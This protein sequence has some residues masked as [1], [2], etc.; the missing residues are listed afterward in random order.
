MDK[1]ILVPPDLPPLFHVH[2][3][4]VRLRIKVVY[5]LRNVRVTVDMGQR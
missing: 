1:A 5:G 3:P 4:I 2:V